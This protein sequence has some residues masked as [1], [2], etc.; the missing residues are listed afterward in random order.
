MMFKTYLYL[1]LTAIF[2][3]NNMN[4]SKEILIKMKE[5]IKNQYLFSFTQYAV[6]YLL[7]ALITIND[8]SHSEKLYSISFILALLNQGDIKNPNDSLKI[9][10]FL[11][12]PLFK[13]CV[14]NSIHNNNNYL[15]EYL[16]ELYYLLDRKIKTNVEI[17][18]KNKKLNL[19]YYCFPYDKCLLNPI[20]NKIENK[21]LDDIN[22]K[23][24]IYKVIIDYF[25]STDNLL[26]DDDFLLFYEINI[27]E[28]KE[29]ENE[30]HKKGE[31][32]NIFNK[33]IAKYILDEM[34]YQKYAPSN[35]V[36]SFGD[37]N[38]SQTAQE[39]SNSIMTPKI[40][41][42]LLNKKFCH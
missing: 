5:I 24:F 31:G 14:I 30:N 41:Y 15:K 11:M 28:D 1:L 37:N 38:Y 26:F 3:Q 9:H 10:Q 35:I 8:L 19:G 22:F 23:N 7:E 18:K 12:F 17:D 36:F 6:L 2:Y 40:I 20:D 25:Y 16:N 32:Y 39:N 4:K 42:T 21:Y 13:L 33:Y 29:K 34:S 27:K